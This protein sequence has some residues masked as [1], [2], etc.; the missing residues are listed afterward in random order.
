MLRESNLLF[1]LFAQN[2]ETTMLYEKN[3]LPKDI[4]VFITSFFVGLSILTIAIAGI[5]RYQKIKYSANF[6]SL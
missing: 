1:G 5:D 4:Y 2:S 3:C 6:K